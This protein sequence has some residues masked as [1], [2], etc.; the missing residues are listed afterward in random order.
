MSV[1]RP[2]QIVNLPPECPEC[3]SPSICVTDL[4]A[5]SGRAHCHD[6][7]GGV[8]CGWSMEFELDPEAGGYTFVSRGSSDEEPV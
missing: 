6:Q 8:E 5:T 7:S 3:G 1:P 2:S 4:N